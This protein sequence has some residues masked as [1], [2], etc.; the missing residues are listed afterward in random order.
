LH[1]KPEIVTSTLSCLQL[2]SLEQLNLKPGTTAYISLNAEPGTGQT[3]NPQY[4]AES[5]MGELNGLRSDCVDLKRSRIFVNRSLTVLK[6]GLVLEHPNTQ[7]D[8][9]NLT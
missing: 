1:L 2:V 5:A 6:G 3:H 4:S 7:F 8:S 9:E